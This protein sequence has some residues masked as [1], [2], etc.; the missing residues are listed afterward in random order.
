MDAQEG[1]KMDP[2]TA[3]VASLGVGI[4]ANAITEFCKNL[5]SKRV[6]KDEFKSR[7]LSAFPDELDS[8]KSEALASAFLNGKPPSQVFN[9]VSNNQFGGI[10]AGVVNINPPK[11]PRSLDSK[12]QNQTISIINQHRKAIKM[13][14]VVSV[15]GDQE[16]FSFANQ[17]LSFIKSSNIEIPTDGVTQALFNSPVRGQSVQIEGS[18]L[19]FIIGTQE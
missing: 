6:S 5:L 18:T 14:E 19:K 4:A 8:S 9:V 17:L 10:T 2:W 3:Y 15:M 1:D 13:I 16:A 12:L 7:L 11:L